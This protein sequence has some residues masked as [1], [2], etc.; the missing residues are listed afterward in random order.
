MII[1]SVCAF[2]KLALNKT[3]DFEY[4]QTIYLLDFHAIFKF[5]NLTQANEP[6]IY[7]ECI[8][9]YM[10][11]YIDASLNHMRAPQNTLLNRNDSLFF[12]SVK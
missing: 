8:Q 12:Y 6:Q 1:V 2:A 7:I 5:L 3:Y 4:N 11:T 9:K 10:H